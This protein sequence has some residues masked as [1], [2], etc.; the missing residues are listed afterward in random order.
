A[1]R[2]AACRIAASR[3][4]ARRSAASKSAACAACRIAAPGMAEIGETLLAVQRHRVVNLRADALRRKMRAQLVPAADADH[5]LIKYVSSAVDDVRRAN[6]AA[7]ASCLEQLRVE[8]G[9]GLARAR[10][11]VEMR[12]FDEQHRGL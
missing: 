6:G 10:P 11:L 7:D 9:V 12:Q 4:A 5:V 3:S 2:S 1:S 8:R